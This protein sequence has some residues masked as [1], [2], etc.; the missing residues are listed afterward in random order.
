M[1]AF[2]KEWVIPIGLIICVLGAIIE[3]EHKE[4]KLKQQRND[5]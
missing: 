3:C 2:I 1:K 5:N 4:V